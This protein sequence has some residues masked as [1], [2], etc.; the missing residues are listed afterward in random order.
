ML[1]V[2]RRFPTLLS[3]RNAIDGVAARPLAVIA[4]ETACLPAPI[5]HGFRRITDGYVDMT[6]SEYLRRWVVNRDLVE[7]IDDMRT[8]AREGGGE[9]AVARNRKVRYITPARPSSSC[10]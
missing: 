8:Q 9:K 6:S 7:R 10:R 4:A 2:S 5:S 1:R 3:S